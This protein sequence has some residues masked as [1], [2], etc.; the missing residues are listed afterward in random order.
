MSND[1]DAGHSHDGGVSQS[2][3][4]FLNASRDAFAA[5]RDL[6]HTEHHYYHG[7]PESAPV[8]RRSGWWQVPSRNL[9]FSGREEELCAI[10][11]ALTSGG[12]ATVQALHGMG[13]I[14]KT[15]L[16]IEYA[17]RFGNE[18]DIVCWIDAGHA[19]LIG[20]QFAVLATDLGCAGPGEQLGQMRRAV[21]AELRQQHGCLLIFDNAESP[22][23]VAD[24]LP[25]GGSHVLIT[26]RAAGW[27][28]F[29]VP[30][31]IGVLGRDDSIAMLRGWVSGL[32]QGDAALVADELDGLPLALAQAAGFMASNGTSATDYVRMLATRTA[33][34]L[35]QRPPRSHPASLSAVTSIAFE[36][37]RGHDPTAAELA[38]IC[39]FL[40]PEPIPA[41]WF[42]SSADHLPHGL[43]ACAADQLAWGQVVGRLTGSTLIRVEPHGLQ[44]H[45][46]TQAIIRDYLPLAESARARE[47]AEMVLIG[48]DPGYP[49]I[50][51]NW[52]GW[53]RMLPHLLAIDPASSA[54][55]NRLRELGLNAAWYLNERGEA[56]S[57]LALA[58]RLLD[59]W[60]AQMGPDDIYVLWAANNAA[61]ALRTLHRFTEA[62][63]LDEDVLARR[64]RLLGNDHPRTLSSLGN[65]AYDLSGLGDYQAARAF[66][67]EALDLRRQ[68]LG[69]DNPATIASAL[70][71]ARNLTLLG[72]L[73]QARELG[74]A[75]LTRAQ[76]VL[77][78]DHPHTIGIALNLA[79]GTSMLGDHAASREQFAEI[80]NRFL[81]RLGADH[82]Y[83]LMA[84][85]NLAEVLRDLD[86]YALARDLDEDTLARRRQVYG[87]DHPLTQESASAL[88]ADLRGLTA[89]ADDEGEQGTAAV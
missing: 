77:G 49:G 43:G 52:P 30:V 67:Q 6:I 73:H 66:D 20:E 37:L 34:A 33:E 14:G 46:L 31:R 5:G 13:G 18:Y 68:V 85:S 59:S 71:L 47:H 88:A 87:A 40:A 22:G 7:A 11:A 83:S 44:M 56:A 24:W 65:L 26:S 81:A 10:H 54:S 48:N 58:R 1:E 2:G 42:S 16:A 55:G 15:Q 32:G 21:L 51:G 9:L 3:K 79:A 35:R 17:H 23:D 41:G 64:R 75:T 60:R 82:P 53:A 50:P 86:E 25:G 38:V 89:G 28:E 57:S 72:E 80:R 63:A 84:A 76:R 4:Q 62:R 45:R 39:A 70:N 69:D 27:Q 36:Q 78:V 74:E 61:E 12:R 8:P 19:A 29:G